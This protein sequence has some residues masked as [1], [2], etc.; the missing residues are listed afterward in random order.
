[1]GLVGRF[2]SL[3]LVPTFVIQLIDL[4]KLSTVYSGCYSL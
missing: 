2:M 4:R 1:M 3:R